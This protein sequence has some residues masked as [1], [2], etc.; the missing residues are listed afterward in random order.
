MRNADA[1]VPVQMVLGAGGAVSF[2]SIFI[3]L[4][5]EFV[6]TANAVAVTCFRSGLDRD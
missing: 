3:A 2:A 6:A 1:N 4:A 5:G